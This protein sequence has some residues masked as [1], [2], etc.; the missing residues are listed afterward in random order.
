MEKLNV[1]QQ[2]KRLCLAYQFEPKELTKERLDRITADYFNDKFDAMEN[3]I[4]ERF[5]EINKQYPGELMEQAAIYPG[6]YPVKDHPLLMIRFF[7]QTDKNKD[8]IL[9]KSFKG[10]H[11]KILHSGSEGMVELIEF[12]PEMDAYLSSI[13]IKYEDMSNLK[14]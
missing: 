6:Y 10:L 2:A 1:F 11:V 14:I 12:K 4:K 5:K 8:E 9:P 13:G 7:C 3:S